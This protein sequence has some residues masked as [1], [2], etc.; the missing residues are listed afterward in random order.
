MVAQRLETNIVSTN[1]DSNAEAGKNSQPHWRHRRPRPRK[2]IEL[3]NKSSDIPILTPN[4]DIDTETKDK[5]DVEQCFIC[6]EPIS[7][8]AVGVCNHRTCHLCSLRLRALYKNPA[9]G[10]CKTELTSVVFTKDP[11]R[12]FESF[13]LRELPAGDEK[14]SVYFETQEL[15]DETMIILRFNCPD[16]NC[17]FHADNGWKELKEHV[18]TVHQRSLCDICIK[19]K[20]IFSHEHT[21]FTRAQLQRHMTVGDSRDPNN[22]TGFKGHPE[23]HFCRISF[24]DGDQLFEHCRDKHEQCHICIRDGSGRNDYYTNYDTLEQHFLKDH[25]LCSDRE[26]LNKKFVVFKSDIDL[27]AH[28]VCE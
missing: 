14:T 15:C 26:C 3:K 20:K 12:T 2:D 11:N 24:Y 22:T 10:Y 13:N 28:V 8:Y 5:K 21:Q 4:T 7:C 18:K 17:D 19:H 6:T 9:C 25:F 16:S 27:K 1:N 23:C